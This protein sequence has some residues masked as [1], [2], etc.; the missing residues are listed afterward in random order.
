MKITHLGKLAM[1]VCRDPIGQNH[2]DSKRFQPQGNVTPHLLTLID[3]ATRVV[4]TPIR[5]PCTG[6]LEP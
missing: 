2:D 5:I 6:I 3:L 4:Y 1:S